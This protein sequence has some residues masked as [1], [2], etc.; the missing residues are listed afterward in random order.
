MP[1]ISPILK[2]ISNYYLLKHFPD[3]PGLEQ[4]DI[5]ERQQLLLTKALRHQLRLTHPANHEDV[6]TRLIL[7]MPYLREINCQHSSVL[8]G[9][10]NTSMAQMLPPLHKEVFESDD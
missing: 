4:R 1:D 3:R 6:F 7:L 2:L 8:I 5:L 10:N 9:L